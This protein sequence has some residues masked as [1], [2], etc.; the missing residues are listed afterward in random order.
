MKRV[1]AFVGS[2]RKRNTHNAV[3]QFLCNLQALG[4]VEYEIVGLKDYR[5]E[6]CRGCKSCFEKGEELCPLHD[7]RDVLI[8]K[9]EASDGVVFASPNYSF[10]VSGL[11]KTFLDRLGFVFHRPRFH[12]KTFTSIVAQG[13][14]GGGKIVKYLDFVGNGL[15]FNTVKGS[16]LGTLEPMTEKAQAKIDRTLACQSRRFHERLLKPAFPVPNLFKLMIFR[17]S[18]TSMKLMLDGSS[19]DYAYYSDKGWFESDYYYPARLG[20]LKKVA[21]SLFD[22]LAGNMAGKAEK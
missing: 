8:K 19:R 2:A 16:C 21:G 1:T 9:I 15:G 20:A 12:G 18:R 4:D 17:M 6:T 14:Y 11:M 7:D 3:L 22:S 13:I 10:Q 5:L